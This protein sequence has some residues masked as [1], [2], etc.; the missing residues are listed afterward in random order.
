LSQVLRKAKNAGAVPETVIVAPDPA[1]NQRAPLVQHINE[2]YGVVVD[3][4]ALPQFSCSLVDKIPVIVPEPFDPVPMVR[5]M[6]NW[7]ETAPYSILKYRVPIES[8]NF[9]ISY[10]TPARVAV[11]QL[12]C[13]VSAVC[14]SIPGFTDPRL[15][16]M[17]DPM[18]RNPASVVMSQ[19]FAHVAVAIS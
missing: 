2:E 10:G 13:P 4:G 7:V 3:I 14:V 8:V 1:S 19:L 9:Q 6:A 17:L 12:A 18:T 11:A 16:L 15:E 5:N